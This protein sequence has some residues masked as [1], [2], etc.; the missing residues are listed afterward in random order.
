MFRALAG[1]AMLRFDDPSTACVPLPWHDASTA[2]VWKW[3]AFAA[4]FSNSPACDLLYRTRAHCAY[5]GYRIVGIV[6][7]HFAPLEPPVERRSIF[8]KSYPHFGKIMANRVAW[9][10]CVGKGSVARCGLERVLS[11]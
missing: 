8:L 7:R 4:F 2:C 9:F 10:C 11:K 3:S 6:V 5:P 1:A